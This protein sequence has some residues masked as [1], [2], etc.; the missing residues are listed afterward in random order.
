M[1]VISTEDLLYRVNECNKKLREEWTESDKVGIIGCDAN[2]LFPS[3]SARNSAR[4]VREVFLES[5]MEVEG[6]DYR[7]A[8][9]YVRFGMTDTEIRAQGL[10]RVMPR[11][12]YA[13]GA[14][15]RII[16]KEALSGDADRDEDKWIFPNVE[17]IMTYTG[18]LSHH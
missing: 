8:A 5:P 11:R 13:R 3:L 6:A 7:S 12:R 16:S 4:I 1:E 10:S 2:A 9:M 15:P 18:V 14:A 17:Q